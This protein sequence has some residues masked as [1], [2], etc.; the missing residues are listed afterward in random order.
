[1]ENGK[2][3][4][5]DG[6]PIE[7]YKSFYELFKNDLLQ[8][9][10]SILFKNDNL[11]LSM[12]KAIINLIPKNDQ[13]EF[14]PNWR[15]FFLLTADYQILTKILSDRLK[16]TLQNTI[17]EEQTYGIPNRSIFSNLF[18]TQ[19]IIAHSTTKK[20]KSHIVSI[21]QEIFPQSR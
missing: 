1:M 6:L 10:N 9:Y 2:S 18:T 4:G 17:S 7:S 3:S 21:D 20:L 11:T 14:L 8:L 19:E 15:P 12:T 5:I 16:P 13:K